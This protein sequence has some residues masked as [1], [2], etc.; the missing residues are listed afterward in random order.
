L[1]GLGE[2]TLDNGTAALARIAAGELGLESD[3]KA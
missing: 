1:L 3:V 2:L